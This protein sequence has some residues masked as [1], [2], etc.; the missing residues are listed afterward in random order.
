MLEFVGSPWIPFALLTAIA[1]LARILSGSWLHPSAFPALVW[2]VFTLAALVVAPGH[3]VVGLGIWS[4]LALTAA[5][6]VGASLVGEHF[7]MRKSAGASVL[8]VRKWVGWV[9]VFASMSLTGAILFAAMAL[10]ENGLPFSFPGLLAL[11]HVLS[12]ARY[13]G[14]QEPAIVR[15]LW[16]WVFPAAALGG[17]TF[18]FARNRLVKWLSM[19]AFVPALLYSFLET[20]RG[21]FVIAMCCW[22]GTF[23][24]AKVCATSGQYQL[25]NR[26]MLMV[27]FLLATI[28]GSVFVVFDSIRRFTPDQAFAVE[29]DY[30]RV[31]A[32]FVGSLSFFDHWIAHDQ[33]SA[34]LTFGTETF[35]SL[36]ELVGLRTWQINPTITLEGG[37]ETNI[38]TAFQGLIQ[39]FTFPGAFLTCLAWGYA[40][41]IAFQKTKQGDVSGVAVLAAYYSLFLFSPIIALT[42]YN[43]PILAWI[44]VAFLLR[45]RNKKERVSE[46]S[47]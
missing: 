40:A 39:D 32:Y 23:L 46:V 28:V 14:V 24:S 21:G 38:P 33:S 4:V 42:A 8:Q 2:S 3:E 36:S 15:A 25:F 16:T 11:G 43:G 1:I 7:G 19:S 31:K 29:P 6:H 12:V 22:L 9:T 20:T 44:V 41:G 18:V 13:A 17:V 30:S 10:S 45:S 27:V 26:R 35:R 5:S 47:L 37:A 34:S